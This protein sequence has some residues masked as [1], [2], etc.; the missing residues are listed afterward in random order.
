MLYGVSLSR[1]LP[2][3]FQGV[4]NNLLRGN[5]SCAFI[6]LIKPSFTG[7]IQH[8]PHAR[9]E[10]ERFRAVPPFPPGLVLPGASPPEHMGILF[11][12]TPA[13]RLAARALGYAR[14]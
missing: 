3:P 5:L 9:H 2:L 13:R 11:E 8:L 10:T 7:V 14:R 12:K 1:G 4:F 6:A